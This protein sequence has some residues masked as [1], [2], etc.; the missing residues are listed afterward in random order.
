[1]SMRCMALRRG[2]RVVFQLRIKGCHFYVVMLG[3]VPN[4]RAYWQP[5]WL[6]LSSPTSNAALVTDTRLVN[7]G[8]RAPRSQ[9]I[10]P[11]L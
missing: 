11:V 2:S 5:K 7:N 3:D 10:L 1:M 9:Q 4:L 6:G 8:R